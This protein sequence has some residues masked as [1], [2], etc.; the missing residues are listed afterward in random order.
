LQKHNIPPAGVLVLR[1]RPREQ[2]LREVL[3][4]LAA[5][6]P[7]LYNA[8]QQSQFPKVEKAFTRAKYIASFIGVDVGKA[9]FA[10]LYALESWRSISFED[11]WKIAAN[12][13]LHD[14]F[15]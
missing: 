3:P 9:L 2:K 15:G 13:E 5:E 1:H 7:D 8:Y 6:R 12:K 11:H 10:G 4:W 14:A